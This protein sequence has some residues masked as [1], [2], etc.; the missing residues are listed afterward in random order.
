MGPGNALQPHHGSDRRFG[1][2]DCPRHNAAGRNMQ[3]SE[4]CRENRWR[5][6]TVYKDAKRAGND[7]KRY[8]SGGF[9]VHVELEILI[10]DVASTLSP[11]KKQRLERLKSAKSVVPLLP[12]MPY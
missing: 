2:N 10:S 12:R 4:E 5:S 6:C 8:H 3:G 11:K 1:R 9:F 7:Q